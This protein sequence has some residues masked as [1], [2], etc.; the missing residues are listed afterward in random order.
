MNTASSA[1]PCIAPASKPLALRLDRLE[2]PMSPGSQDIAFLVDGLLYADTHS[3][4]HRVLDLNLGMN[5][6]PENDLLLI[7]QA[8]AKVWVQHERFRKKTTAP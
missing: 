4:T 2:T 3:N 1:L 7:A 6:P 8:F 5:E